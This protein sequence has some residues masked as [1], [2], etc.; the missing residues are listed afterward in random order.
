MHRLV[1][2]ALTNRAYRSLI[3]VEEE[4]CDED[5]RRSTCADRGGR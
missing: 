1:L 5:G 2:V 4:N 3:F